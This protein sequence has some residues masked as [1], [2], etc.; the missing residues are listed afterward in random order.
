M[1]RNPGGITYDVKE[2][3]HGRRPVYAA[4]ATGEMMAA[5]ELHAEGGSYA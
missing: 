2:I 1:R 5:E 4:V 3:N